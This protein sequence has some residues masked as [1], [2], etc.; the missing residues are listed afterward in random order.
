[1][2][3]EK[4]EEIAYSL[5]DKRDS[6]CFHVAFILKKKRILSIGWNKSATHPLTKKYNYQPFAKTHAELAAVIRLGEID[7]SNL[8]LAVLRINKNDK[9]DSS[10]PC[11]GCAHMI[12]QLNFRNVY[13]TSSD[14]NWLQGV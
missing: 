6:R 9:I 10:K 8:D 14:G 2:R 12:K 11:S 3:F 4:L 5:L 13:Y 7:C 1:M